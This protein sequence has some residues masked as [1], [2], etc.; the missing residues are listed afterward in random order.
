MSVCCGFH[1]SLVSRPF[2]AKNMCLYPNTIASSETDL[3]IDVTFIGPV[4][5]DIGSSSITKSNS[6]QGISRTAT[7]IP[8]I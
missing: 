2:T 3:W 5:I 7:V 8:E 4:S 6:Y 1:V